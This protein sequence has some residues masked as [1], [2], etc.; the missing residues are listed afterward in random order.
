MTLEGVALGPFALRA[1]VKRGQRD[2]NQRSLAEILEFATNIDPRSDLQHHAFS[3]I[4][5]LCAYIKTVYDDLGRRCRDLELPPNWPQVGVYRLIPG[6][7]AKVAHRFTG[8]E[9]ELGYDFQKHSVDDM[10][11][12][13]NF[14]ELRAQVIAGD[15]CVFLRTIFRPFATPASDQTVTPSPAKRQKQLRSPSFLRHAAGS[16]DT[17]VLSPATSIALSDAE[18]GVASASV[19]EAALGEASASEHLG[20]DA[21]DSD[22]EAR[23]AAGP[24][25]PPP[26]EGDPSTAGASGRAPP[27]V[28]EAGGAPGF[29]EATAWDQPPE[30]KTS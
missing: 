28:A 1:L 6:P 25:D 24:S 4:E 15:V 18:V 30:D 10:T 17:S 29:G 12:V 21:E 27:A 3:A 20:G 9:I 8:E 14:S 19:F 11:L 2:L 16:N 22:A 13:D 26:A 5:E 23:A 7:L